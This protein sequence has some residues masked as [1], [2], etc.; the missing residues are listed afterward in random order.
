MIALAL[1]AAPPLA[2]EMDFDALVRSIGACD[3]SAVT[4]TIKAADQRHA[5]FLLD[6]YKEQRSIALART[7]LAERRRRLR[8]KEAKVDTEEVL[9]LASDALDERA[10]ALTENRALDHSEQDMV[11]YF[12]TQYLRQC[13]GKGL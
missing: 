13:S 6:A 5:G 2:D 10:R 8:A 11:A 9:T 4:G 12:R 1:A 7:D 3:R